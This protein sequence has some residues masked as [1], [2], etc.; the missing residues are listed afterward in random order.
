[1]WTADFRA[2]A[3]GAEDCAAGVQDLRFLK[4]GVLW[5]F[6][7]RPGGKQRRTT[8]SC[9]GVGVRPPLWPSE[10]TTATWRG[11]FVLSSTAQRLGL[12]LL[13]RAGVRTVSRGR[14]G[15]CARVRAS[16]V[17]VCVLPGS[18]PSWPIPTGFPGACAALGFLRRPPPQEPPRIQPEGVK[19]G[20]GGPNG[21]IEL[22]VIVFFLLLPCTFQQG[23]KSATLPS[24][25]RTRSMVKLR[26]PGMHFFFW[27]CLSRTV[28]ASLEAPVVDVFIPAYE[29]AFPM[30]S[31]LMHSLEIFMPCRNLVHLVVERSDVGKSMVWY[32]LESSIRIHSFDPPKALTHVLSLPHAGYFLQQWVM[33][34]ADEYLEATH[35]RARYVMFLDTDTVMALPV[36]TKSLFD[37]TG[38]LYQLSWNISQQKQFQPSCVDFVGDKCDVSYM[39]TFPFTMPVES[40]GR[41][42]EFAR[43]RLSQN[44]ST[45]DD[46]VNSWTLRAEYMALSQFCIM[47]AYMRSHEPGRVRQIFC[48]TVSPS[49]STDIDET[50]AS[51]LCKNYVPSV[52]HLGWGYRPYLNSGFG[53]YRGHAPGEFSRYSDKYGL[54]YIDAAQE[55]VRHGYCLMQNFNGQQTSNLT[56]CT[57]SDM[58]SIPADIDL[59]GAHR[60][61]N[62]TIVQ[63]TFSLARVNC[64]RKQDQR[65]SFGH[66]LTRYTS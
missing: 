19:G 20:G 4:E 45:F 42:R 1:M 22:P 8:C 56:F 23:R 43:S 3:S 60:T 40:I 39:S 27:L 24:V 5:V 21:P 50:D 41:L 34:H 6:V 7:A 55:I 35:S 11:S 61:L 33:F 26:Q 64:R 14:D 32:N 38:R 47:G 17:F 15:F 31:I 18:G 9:S 16:C 65:K 63:E 51:K 54:S 37:E 58:S 57:A 49:F 29:A 59:Y 52:A 12:G 66:H 13:L 44:A 10:S 46:A 36:T 48:P 28:I 2:R 53:G 25:G 30:L 62:W